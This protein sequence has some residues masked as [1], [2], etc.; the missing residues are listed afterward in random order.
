[1]INLRNQYAFLRQIGKGANAKIYL[2]IDQQ[3]LRPVAIKIQK[4]TFKNREESAEFSREVIVSLTLEAH[5]HVAEYYQTEYIQPRLEYQPPSKKKILVGRVL[6]V[7]E[8]INGIPIDDYLAKQDGENHI[9]LVVKYIFEAARALCDL[10]QYFF[11]L[12]DKN[13]GGREFMHGDLHPGN[14]MVTEEGRLVVLDWGQSFRHRKKRSNE[15]WPHQAPEFHKKSQFKISAK[16]DVFALG[17]LCYR[18]LTGKLPFPVSKNEL[19]QDY[20]EFDDLVVSKPPDFSLLHE[21][22]SDLANI[23]ARMLSINPVDRW[24][25]HRVADSVYELIRGSYMSREPSAPKVRI[26][27]SLTREQLNRRAESLF[28]LAELFEKSVPERLDEGLALYQLALDQLGTYG[29]G[30]NLLEADVS[31]WK[32]RFSA[33]MAN[34]GQAAKVAPHFV[35]LN[36]HLPEIVEATRHYYDEAFRGN[37]SEGLTKLIR[38]ASLAEEEIAPHFERLVSDILIQDYKQNGARHF[39]RYFRLISRFVLN[40]PTAQPR[41]LQFYYSHFLGHFDR[42]LVQMETRSSMVRNW[43]VRPYIVN[44][45]VI[46]DFEA[47]AGIVC[48]LLMMI[49]IKRM[50]F[51]SF[52]QRLQYNGEKNLMLF[53][54]VCEVGLACQVF[55][56][57]RLMNLIHQYFLFPVHAERGSIT[58]SEIYVETVVHFRSFLVTAEFLGY[59]SD[60]T[61]YGIYW[62]NS[63]LSLPFLSEMAYLQSAKGDNLNEFSFTEF[64][65]KLEILAHIVVRQDLKSYLNILLERHRGSGNASTDISEF[66]YRYWLKLSDD[67]LIPRNEDEP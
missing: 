3:N 5:R 40:R 25:I 67:T 52:S 49:L 43:K 38:T 44:G 35:D 57:S 54:T 66:T 1:M 58:E 18:M 61:H 37:F 51:Q 24:D 34:L 12:E 7:M 16:V 14:L 2:A 19:G 26:R 23:V 33:K 27:H 41:I 4:L 36:D 64:Y 60:A 62:R 9:Y 32:G 39:L 11:Y 31:F 21:I 29:T 13:L 8:A 28:S 65:G 30:D 59:V 45:E 20:V 6:T 46:S 56:F 63:F 22:N 42:Q 50:R 15:L 47:D 17:V 53:F 55:S 48:H 10:T